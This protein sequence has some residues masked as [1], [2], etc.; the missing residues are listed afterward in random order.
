MFCVGYVHFYVKEGLGLD[1]I[2][3]L[4]TLHDIWTR[5]IF[6]FGQDYIESLIYDI[7]TPQ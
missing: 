3:M 5:Q 6:I 2:A 1:L 7:F 4:I